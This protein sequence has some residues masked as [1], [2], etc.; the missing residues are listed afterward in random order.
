MM[1]RKRKERQCGEI[2]SWKC[3]NQQLKLLQHLEEE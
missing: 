1:E 2:I 3:K